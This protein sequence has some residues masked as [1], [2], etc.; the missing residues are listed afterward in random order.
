MS[1]IPSTNKQAS[2]SAKSA[3]KNRRNRDKSKGSNSQG[4]VVASDAT[5]TA[6]SGA[7][8]FVTNARIGNGQSWPVFIKSLVDS[9]AR[10]Q[11]HIVAQTIKDV[12]YPQHLTKEF[13][14]L[15]LQLRQASE[16]FD[17]VKISSGEAAPWDG[18]EAMMYEPYKQEINN[19]FRAYF[20]SPD[21]ST[22]VQRVYSLADTSGKIELKF[23]VMIAEF[24]ACLKSEQYQRLV[25]DEFILF[26]RD[27]IPQVFPQLEPFRAYVPSRIT[28]FY[29]QQAKQKIQLGPLKTNVDILNSMLTSKLAEIAKHK[30]KSNVQ[31]D[32]VFNALL[33]DN[34]ITDQTFRNGL[35]HKEEIKQLQRNH[36]ILGLLMVIK[37]QYDPTF[38][39]VDIGAKLVA[40]Q[41]MEPRK[42]ESFSDFW[43]RWLNEKIECVAAGCAMPNAS[44]SLQNIQD[45]LIKRYED[46]NDKFITKIVERQ[47]LPPTNPDHREAPETA[48]QFKEIIYDL[49]RARNKAN[50]AK[51]NV[52]PNLAYRGKDSNS[53]GD[54]PD[55]AKNKKSNNSDNPS[56]SSSKVSDEVDEEA[57][58]AVNKSGKQQQQNQKQQA[59]GTNP[60]PPC[61]VCPGKYHF[62]NT[63]PIINATSESRSAYNAM[64]QAA[65]KAA[66]SQPKQ[67]NKA[68]HDANVAALSDRLS[69]INTDDS[70]SFDFVA[71]YVNAAVSIGALA[72][73]DR[74]SVLYDPG[75]QV[76]IFNDIGSF[77]E[78]SLDFIAPSA[79]QPYYETTNIPAHSRGHIAGI[80]TAYYCPSAVNLISSGSLEW[81]GWN[82]D[83]N[84][85]GNFTNF[86]TATVE[87]SNIAV[88]F[89]RY[90]NRWHAPLSE[91]M[92]LSSINA[93]RLQQA[94][95]SS[96]NS[97]SVVQSSYQLRNRK[98]Q[99]ESRNSDHTAPSNSV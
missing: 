56:A 64:I 10:A 80:G 50:P 57:V 47:L 93:K 30:E 83:A 69:G 20:S 84:K 11:L 74:D 18:N 89:N 72:I 40:W 67:N 81:L 35:I 53:K 58:G 51:R 66:N 34:I 38:N 55:A 52:D 71:Y 97:L 33:L 25:Y 79:I 45:I 60:K 95:N 8:L 86:V 3:G 39:T 63:C 29:A 91:V 44:I 43:S 14:Q 96:V 9:C 49:I 87:G 16:N 65:M 22:K 78:G 32:L 92:Q 27:L 70:E 26:V 23:S 41:K 31:Y 12:E 4:P 85:T 28:Q 61:A 5:K 46:P 94:R 59:S 17:L 75:A 99:N 48:E 77:D 19:Y 36:D 62:I 54:D 15:Q 24:H 1:T 82:F 98:V 13:Q 7:T 21:F 42:G 6:A 37:N 68:Q 88:V 73:Y 90:S 2:D 76:N